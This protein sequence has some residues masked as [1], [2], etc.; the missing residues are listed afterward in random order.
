MAVRAGRYSPRRW[1]EPHVSITLA[2]CMQRSSRAGGLDMSQ[3]CASQPGPLVGQPDEGLGLQEGR[4]LPLSHHR[5][6]TVCGTRRQ[7]RQ[8]P[9]TPCQ[10]TYSPRCERTGGAPAQ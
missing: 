10:A 8:Q 1:G 6:L 9:A 2:T 7:H 3:S 4:R 5:Q